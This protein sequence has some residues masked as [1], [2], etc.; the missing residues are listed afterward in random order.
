M[1]LGIFAIGIPVSAALFIRSS[2]AHTRLR[3]L[4]IDA[5]RDELGLRASLG[6]IQL[7]LFPLGIAAGDVALDDPV[8]GRVADAERIRIRPSFRAL[9]RGM[10]D[11]DRIELD[12]AHVHLVIRDGQL[13]N[14]PRIDTGGGGSGAMTLP[15][16][17][18]SITDSTLS[19]DADPI[20]SGEV[21]ANRIIVRG[22]PGG[23]IDVDIDSDGGHV[24]HAGGR[25]D[26]RNVD[27]HVEIA[28]DAL[29]VHLADV[30]AGPLH[31]A[32]REGIV[33]LP[34]ASPFDDGAHGTVGEVEVDY[35]LEH[36]ATLPLP[37]TLPPMSGHLALRA[38]VRDD[39]TQGERVAGT[40]Q[41]DHGRIT[42]F[43]LGDVVRIAFEAQREQL[44]ITAGEVRVSGN[45]GSV[46]LTGTIG[47]LGDMPVDLRA[48]LR[49]LS[50]AHLM[51]QLGVT[52]NSIVE[53]IF[54]GTMLL[55][56]P[57]LDLDLEGP[58]DL[59][60]HDFFVATGPY[61]ATPVDPVIAIPHGHFRGRWSIRPDGIRFFRLDAALPRSRILGD[62]LLGFDNQL[63]VSARAEPA[64]LRDVSPLSDF[65]MAGI[66]SASCEIV[67]TFQAP[68]VSGHM[69][70]A[71][72]E[73][74]GMRIG[75][76][77][78]DAVLDPD[79]M[80]V[81]FPHV[82][83]SKNDS[84]FAADDVYLD[85][86][87]NR[88]HMAGR[89]R[90]DRMHLADFY[91][92]FGFED[93]ERFVSYQG[94]ANGD[95]IIDY[96]NGYPGDARSGTLDVQMDL[97]L[98]E[99]TVSGYR[100]TDGRLAGHFRWLDW[101]RGIAGA[102]LTIDHAEL[103]KGEGSVT[104]A[105]TMALGGALAFTAS[106]DAIAVRDIEG[107][108]DR[109]PG[110]DGITSITAQVSGTPDTMRVDM[111]VGLTSLVYSGRPL[112]DGRAYV[113]MTHQADAWV[114]EALSWAS[115]APPGEEC[116]LAR[117]GLAHAT[118]PADP[119]M[120]T[121][122]GLQPRLSRPSAFL[123]CGDALGG[124]LRI[125]LAVGRTSQFPLRGRI[126]MD[127][128]DLGA[129]IPPAPGAP[130]ETPE[131]AQASRGKLSGE[132]LI[133]DGG[134]VRP[135]TL[136]ARV[137]LTELEIGRGDLLL[138]ND[139]EL[140]LSVKDGVA[141]VDRA[142]FVGPN[143]RLRVRGQ[144]T[145]PTPTT[146]GGLALSVRGDLDL[147]LV[148]RVIPAITSAEGRARAQLSLSGP[149]TDPEVYGE[150]ELDGASLHVAGL[151]TAIEEL[152]ARVTFSAR[153]IVIEDVHGRIAG[154][155]VR[156]HGEATIASRALERYTIALAAQDLVLA[157][158][159]GLDVALSA[160]VQLGWARGD[161]LPML[162]GEIRVQR[163]AYTRSIDLGTSLGELARTQRAEVERYD[164]NAERVA[165]DLRVI[166]QQPFVVRNNLVD[167]EL[168]IDASSGPLRVV[169]TDQRYGLL[170]TM[171][172]AHGRIFFRNATFDVMR[173]SLSFDDESR[174]D[175]R[176]EVHAITEIARRASA[177]LSA[178]R[179]RV[180][181]DAH[182]TSE[183]FEIQTRSDPDLPQDDILMLLAV[184]M[185]RSEL[186]ALQAGDVTG[187]AALETLSALTGVDREVRRAVPLID[188]FRIGSGYSP[189]TGRTEP[190]VSVGR[191]LTERVRISAT[192]GVGAGQQRDFRAVVDAQ[193]TDE[194][195]AQCSYDNF[196]STGSA[197]SF[198][199]VGCDL[200]F[201]LEFE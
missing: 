183:E 82:V 89:L 170:G 201:R 106:A 21:H 16:H 132:L 2:Q 152:G 48:Q 26:I 77:E 180:L 71:G 63:R 129:L 142:R 125:D 58:I 161:R 196:S 149:I 165:L 74:D 144:Y 116:S 162:G 109:F 3:Q 178:P 181:L 78:S 114:Q 88:F 22:E 83:A 29:R 111:D 145:L 36:L 18:L 23:V 8:Y 57:L 44:R 51:D 97:G 169:G 66:G 187:T 73:F 184:G 138:T 11:I 100:F 141:S 188:D 118:W 52:P 105:G 72:F 34:L 127:G 79:G 153:R 158:V 68:H 56:G 140:I 4:A 134:L 42:E 33:P 171:Q 157:P 101:S 176:F 14:V 135:E 110:L 99:A 19:V 126:T 94:V 167:A 87:R 45:G 20:A 189:T 84:R 102:Q 37:I 50:F 69:R 32:V 107:L 80:G 12:G 139:G 98:G 9:L 150:A 155:T 190:Q 60:T 25:D 154:G 200:R 55:Q 41:L 172:F 92:V 53:W 186:A 117:A 104:L 90:L 133:L 191:R 173:G 193:L 13:R 112:G 123:I 64:D 93:D 136:H 54:D 65:T 156:G 96:T 128:L 164:P 6:P 122:D 120:R 119:P 62:V 27:A 130:P 159:D 168:V 195:G 192:T 121:R 113:R 39:R 24:E 199:N 151:P 10:I 1:I 146:E 108:G 143:S 28:A 43:G 15:F 85:F 61:H 95:A 81:T 7:E 177:D 198:G 166:D 194:V 131:E 124:R 86:R 197:S 163:L 46:D 185:T 103:R 67:G 182:G 91:H 49:G 148:T 35:D 160:D 40:L 47:L 76:V 147:A 179:W 115:T 137:R 30:A 17:E 38:Q 59:R 70:L 5:L 75:D 175:P 31:V 174:I